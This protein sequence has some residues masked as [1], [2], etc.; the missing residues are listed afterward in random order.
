M[1]DIL[2]RAIYKGLV[3]KGVRGFNQAKA[4]TVR[5]FAG[6]ESGPQYVSGRG[7]EHFKVTW[8]GHG[9]IG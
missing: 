6:K 5:L 4:H 2:E 8:E 9:A 1:E 7:S 3:Y